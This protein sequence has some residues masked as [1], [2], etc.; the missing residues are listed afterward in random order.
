MYKKSLFCHNKSRLKNYDKEGNILKAT[1]VVRRIDDLGRIVIPK[2]IRKTMHIKN[3]ENLEIFVNND[4][5][6]L[7][8]YSEIGNIKEISDNISETLNTYLKANIL[9]SD[10]DK[11]ISIAGSLKNKYLNKEI[12]ENVLKCI[13]ER[14]I[15]TLNSLKITKEEME[16]QNIILCPIIS[17]GDSLG[18]IIVISKKEIDKNQIEIINLLSKVLAKHIES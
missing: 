6:I 17:N 18:S 2:E 11:Y 8:K 3:G 12:S 1:G 15:K 10:T 13:N 9:I 4:E 7:K 14:K 16:N 5:I